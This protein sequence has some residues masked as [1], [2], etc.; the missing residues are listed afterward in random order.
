VTQAGARSGAVRLL[1]GLTISLFF[2]VATVSRVDLAEVAAALRRVDFRGVALAIPIVFIELGLRSLRWRRLLAPM[3]QVPLRR[4]AAYLAIGYFANS[5]LPARLGDV[6]RA[7]LAGQAF[8]VSRLSVLGTVVVER[9][10]DGLFIL[11][12]VAVLGVTVAGGGSLAT[13]AGWLVVLAGVGIGG[14]VVGFVYLRSSGEG[15]IRLRARSLIDRVLIGAAALRAPSGLAVVVG[16]TI[17]AF[18]PAVVMFTV[19]VAAAGVQLSL[20]QCALVIGGLAL[21]TSIPAAPGS[22]GTYEFVGLTILT[23]LGVNADVALALVV[24]V[25][26]VVTLPLALVGL[27]AAWRLHFRVSDI[28][29]DAEPAVLARDDL[30]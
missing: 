8:G 13:T 28:A 15:R 20:L 17:A 7:Y 16:L 10:A 11:G 18:I 22:L 6:A 2:V 3:A 4:A 21:S 29:H 1:V 5:M 25:H 14:L 12:L 27:I 9:L 23:T 26:L 30:G 24:V 19:I